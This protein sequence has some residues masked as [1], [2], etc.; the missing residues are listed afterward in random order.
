MAISPDLL[1]LCWISEAEE[2]SRPAQSCSVGY[3]VPAAEKTGVCSKYTHVSTQASLNRP[4]SP[5][6]CMLYICCYVNF[7]LVIGFRTLNGSWWVVG[8][9]APDMQGPTSAPGLPVFS[10][11]C[12]DTVPSSLA[13]RISRTRSGRS[14]HVLAGVNHNRE[15]PVKT[16][17]L[18]WWLVFKT[19]RRLRCGGIQPGSGIAKTVRANANQLCSEHQSA[20]AVTLV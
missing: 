4:G 10:F 14:V 11:E 8:V 3:C 16:C 12:A 20:N 5:V 18:V 19:T 13:Y 9:R 1:V 6:Y 2:W 17:D 15:K 7:L